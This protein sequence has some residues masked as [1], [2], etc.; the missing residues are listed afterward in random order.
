[1]QNVMIDSAFLGSE[2]Q[3][4][5]NWTTYLNLFQARVSQMLGLKFCRND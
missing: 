1:M 3:V 5:W 2:I 4:K